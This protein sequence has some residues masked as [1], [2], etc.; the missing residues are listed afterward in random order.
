MFNG[1]IKSNRYEQRK[2]T[3]EKKYVGIISFFIYS[4]T[5]NFPVHMQAR[6]S[7]REI[8]EEKKTQAKQKEKKKR[9]EKNCAAAN[10]WKEHVNKK[11]VQH[12]RMR[13]RREK[14]ES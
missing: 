4:F 11:K 7:A 14:S 10:K 8:K 12:E 9:K 1:T 5:F 3:R 13:D 6:L 2:R